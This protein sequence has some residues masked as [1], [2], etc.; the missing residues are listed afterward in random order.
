MT[1]M[2]APLIA[3]IKTKD[4][5]TLQSLVMTMMFVPMIAVMH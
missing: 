4:V 2:L 1:T 5:L 3:V